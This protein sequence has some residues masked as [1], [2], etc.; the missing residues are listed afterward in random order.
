M[1]R[2]TYVPGIYLAAV[3][4]V[5]SINWQKSEPR[6]SLSLIRFQLTAEF[7]EWTEVAAKSSQFTARDFLVEYGILITTVVS[8]LLFVAVFSKVTIYRSKLVEQAER[9]S[10]N[11][12]RNHK[13]SADNKSDA[14]MPPSTLNVPPPDQK[15]NQFTETERENQ[16]RR[17]T[18]SKAAQRAGWQCLENARQMAIICGVQQPLYHAPHATVVSRTSIVPNPKDPR[19]SWPPS[20]GG[21]WKIQ[22]ESPQP[23]HLITSPLL[24]IRPPG[25][26]WKFETG[27]TNKALLMHDIHCTVL[28]IADGHLKCNQQ[29]CTISGAYCIKLNLWN[30][31]GIFGLSLLTASMCPF[32]LAP[33]SQPWLYHYVCQSQWLL[34]YQ[35]VRCQLQ[36]NSPWGSFKTST[37]DSTPTRKLL[38]LIMEGLP[39]VSWNWY[40]QQP[41][42]QLHGHFTHFVEPVAI[43]LT[44]PWHSTRVPQSITE[45]LL[46][47]STN[48]IC[49][50]NS[51]I[52]NE[53]S[54]WWVVASGSEKPV[55]DVMVCD[56]Q[57]C[58]PIRG[59]V[60]SPIFLVRGSPIW[61]RAGSRFINGSI[62]I[63]IISEGTVKSFNG[64]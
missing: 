36:R 50:G 44:N 63:I 10:R 14:L 57:G 9:R 4:V 48:R 38:S 31:Y 53:R 2:S 7:G 23:T 41:K 21:W 3:V 43:K 45:S 42:M 35:R 51:M 19:W 22:S 54:C 20:R 55:L 30:T 33:Y 61:R 32:Q 11:H 25:C 24:K 49:L 60:R 62:I 13:I 12:H 40:W 26:Y 5:W 18:P 34:H 8:L 46:Q 28:G 37:S 59:T 64:R 58:S 27:R 17:Q 1:G 15:P 52:P 16:W 56:D 6:I 29:A 39:I 47:G